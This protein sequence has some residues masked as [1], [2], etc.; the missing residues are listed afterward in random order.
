MN[1][2]AQD[3]SPGDAFGAYKISKLLGR[4]GMGAVYEAVHTD[5]GRVVALKL[6]SVELD[7]MDSRQRFLREGQTAAAIN[8]PNAVYI[9]GT[10]EINGV[11][12]ISM[13][14]VPGGNLEDKV[15]QRGP[16]PIDE[17]VENILQV[18][19]GLDAALSAGVLHRDVKPANCF[20][21]TSGVP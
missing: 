21:S 17:A 3:L 15:K 10:E 4:G 1:P 14:L 6:L 16:L 12:V 20:V 9:Y 2:P 7:N 19:D 18:I 11:P 13:E 5:D 8:H